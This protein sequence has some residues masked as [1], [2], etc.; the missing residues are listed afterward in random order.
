MNGPNML[1]L[2]YAW[3]ERLSRDKPCTSLGPF[4]GNKKRNILGIRPLIFT[5]RHQTQGLYSKHFFFVTL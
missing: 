1:V 4:V 3:L 2:H 5:D